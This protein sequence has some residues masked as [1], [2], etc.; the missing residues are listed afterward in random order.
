MS[1]KQKMIT[2]VW[3][4]ITMIATMILSH[5]HLIIKEI[6]AHWPQEDTWEAR[7]E[8]ALYTQ[9]GL[10]FVS[11]FVIGGVILLRGH[12]ARTKDDEI[13]RR[14]LAQRERHERSAAARHEALMSSLTNLAGDPPSKKSPASGARPR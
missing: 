5:G 6:M 7:L 3:C 2:T 14:E 10:V 9:G 13:A 1:P 8:N 11:S 12:F 4:S